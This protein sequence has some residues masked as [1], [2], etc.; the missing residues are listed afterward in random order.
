MLHLYLDTSYD[1]EIEV[2]GMEMR[3]GDLW[4]SG[5]SND[6]ALFATFQRIWRENSPTSNH[7]AFRCCVSFLQEELISLRPLNNERFVTECE[8]ATKLPEQS[9]LWA[10]WQ[11]TKDDFS[12]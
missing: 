12:T 6:P 5:T 10:L 4:P 8:R 9:T 3:R 1:A 2:F 7:A 11:R